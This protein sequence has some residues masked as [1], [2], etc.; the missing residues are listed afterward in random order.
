M[1]DFISL[2]CLVFESWL[3]IILSIFSLYHFQVEAGKQSNFKFI[4]ILAGLREWEI[5]SPDVSAAVEFCREKIVEMN[6]DEYEKW[7]GETFPSISRLQPQNLTTKSLKKEEPVSGH[8]SGNWNR[9]K[10][11]PMGIRQTRI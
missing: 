6:V 10:S 2:E 7:F 9:T 3:D 1:F 4:K 11:A 8:R 5:C